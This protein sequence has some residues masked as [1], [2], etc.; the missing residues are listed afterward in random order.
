[1][2]KQIQKTINYQDILASVKEKHNKFVGKFS[3]S[4]EK[5]LSDFWM[6]LDLTYAKLSFVAKIL[7]DA[8]VIN[9]YKE[10]AVMVEGSTFHRSVALFTDY[11]TS[12]I[13]LLN[14]GKNIFVYEGVAIEHPGNLSFLVWSQND[15]TKKYSAV[16]SDD[17]DWKEF[18]L[19]VTDVI[20]KSSYRR[21]EVIEN[22]IG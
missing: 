15:Q 2:N 14:Y 17:F 10:V 22:A 18:T 8:K 5:V 12:F 11:G 9:N 20:H 7:K 21:K 4:I 13:Y 19:Y 3:S 16:L 1:M 6:E